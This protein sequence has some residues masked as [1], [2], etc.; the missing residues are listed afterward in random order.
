MDG[1]LA[2]TNPDPTGSCYER[3]AYALKRLHDIVE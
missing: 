1:S 2:G 3:N